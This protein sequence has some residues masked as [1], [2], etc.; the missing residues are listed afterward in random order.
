MYTIQTNIDKFAEN[1][2][3]SQKIMTTKELGQ[4][5]TII[6][7][8]LEIPLLS[9]TRDTPLKDIGGD[10]PD[11]VLLIMTICEHFDIDMAFDEDEK[12]VGKMIDDIHSDKPIY[13]LV[14]VGDL[15]D[16]V[17]KYL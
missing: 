16:A 5:M 17:D 15:V 7:E 11:I 4:L 14:T 6:S 12:D 13:G 3:K 1:H 9:F 2:R 8:E 10:N